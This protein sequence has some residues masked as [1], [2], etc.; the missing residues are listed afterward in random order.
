MRGSGRVGRGLVGAVGVDCLE[1]ISAT[2]GPSVRLTGWAPFAAMKVMTTNLRAVS[3]VACLL[4]SPAA[5]RAQTVLTHDQ[6]SFIDLSL[7][8]S[9]VSGPRIVNDIV[10]SSSGQTFQPVFVSGIDR[11]VFDHGNGARFLVQ[12]PHLAFRPTS[13]AWNFIGV[14]PNQPFR[15]TPQNGD[16]STRLVLSI[17]SINFP[18]GFFANDEI[19]VTLSTAGISNPGHFSLYT[20]DD[21]FNDP[22]GQLDTV[23]LSTLNNLFSFTRPAGTE[24][25]FNLA[26]SAPG[27]YQLDFH[28]SGTRPPENGGGTVV[29]DVY[30]Y[31]FD[32]AA[33][34]E[35]ATW[36]LLAGATV[37]AAG[38]VVWQRR[39]KRKQLENDVEST[40]RGELA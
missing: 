26:F 39:R 27:T 35:P 30:R 11:W 31:R 10:D 24:N 1:R 12:N 32:V 9:S 6:V 13:G 37:T 22:T 21:S 15:A 18:S 19:T 38:G 25:N 5:V 7:D 8:E 23:Y 29:S 28:F 33:I 20:N 34:P 2:N 17:S 4:L 36:G 40:N 14:G 16:P 3:L